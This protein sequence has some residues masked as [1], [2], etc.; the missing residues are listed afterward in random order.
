M[1]AYSDPLYAFLEIDSKGNLV[2]HGRSG[3]FTKQPP[4][5]T[6]SVIGRSASLSDRKI[7]IL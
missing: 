7:K 1:F 3:R 4:A 6:N 2:I 5:T